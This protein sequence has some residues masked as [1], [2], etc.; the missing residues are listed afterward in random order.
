MLHEKTLAV[1]GAGMMGG[2]LAQGLVRAGALPASSL[3]LFDVL[4]VKAQALADSLG[5][6]AALSALGA[7]TGVDLI[8]LAVKP[9]QIA[10]VLAEIAPVLTPQQT[11][12]SIAAGITLAKM[13]S[14]LPGSIPLIRVMPNTPSLVGEGMAAL[15]RGT[16]A[17][18]ENLRLAQS[19]FS[20]VG[21]SVEVEER[22]LDAVTGVS[23]SGP[24]YVFLIIEAL[25]DGG[26]KQGLP[27]QIARQLAA[28]TVLGA[29]RMV[30]SSDEHPAQLKDNVTTPGGTTIAGLSV[31]ERSGL[32]AAL[33]DA[34]EA[35][36]ARSRELS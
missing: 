7:A 9:P 23:G 31:L 6:S 24:A 16:H 35:A 32:R 12:I 22:L 28:Q 27:R 34:V 11:I 26:V 33:I 19:L 13:E 20:A 30:L 18:D 36:A 4:P 29:A 17:K 14:L 15:C 10:S 21:Q 25:S 1:L 5:A 2:A 3:R 8:L